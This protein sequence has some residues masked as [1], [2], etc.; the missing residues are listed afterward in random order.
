MQCHTIL[1]SMLENGFLDPEAHNPVDFVNFTVRASKSL[2]G[3]LKKAKSPAE[4]S[5]VV[6]SLFDAGFCNRDR[7][8][9]PM[10][11]V[12]YAE[13]AINELKGL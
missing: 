4:V 10:Q 1:Q 13:T 3:A 9:D 2:E 11:W 5:E 6:A 12:M 8:K 7:E